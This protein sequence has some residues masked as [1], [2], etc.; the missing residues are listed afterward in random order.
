VIEH[1]LIGWIDLSALPRPRATRDSEGPQERK[2]QYLGL[3]YNFTLEIL[4]RALNLTKNR[5]DLTK[6]WLVVNV[7]YLSAFVIQLVGENTHKKI[8]Q[9][10]LYNFVPIRQFGLFWLTLTLINWQLSFTIYKNN[11]QNVS[12]SL[13][14]LKLISNYYLS[15]QTSKAAGGCRSC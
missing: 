6:L 9:T 11:H 12:Q 1:W 7:V 2:V 5:I 14:E 8:N 10:Y 15:S 3:L 13:L 4:E